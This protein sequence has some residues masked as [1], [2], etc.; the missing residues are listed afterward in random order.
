M[1]RPVF[2]RIG[3]NAWKTDNIPNQADGF[4]LSTP[5][6]PSSPALMRILPILRF[7]GR[8]FFGF[9][10][11]LPALKNAGNGQIYRL[12]RNRLTLFFDTSSYLIN[13][14]YT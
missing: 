1:D 8:T 7:M 5:R 10:M 11:R 3:A 13:S 4:R 6:H 2:G 14:L 12:L 9:F